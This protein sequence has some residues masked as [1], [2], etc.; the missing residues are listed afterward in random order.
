MERRVPVE[1]MERRAPVEI[2]NG[3]H[4]EK[5]AT[6]LHE[7]RYGTAHRKCDWD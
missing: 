3:A 4:I 5:Y 2:W 6:A 7:I 1:G